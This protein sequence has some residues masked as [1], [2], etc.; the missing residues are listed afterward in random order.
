M[1]ETPSHIDPI[2][3][4]HETSDAHFKSVLVTGI[5]LLG[6]MVFGFVFSW[7]VYAFFNKQTASPGSHAE[8]L[9]RPDLSKRPAGPVLQADPHAELIALRRGEDSVLSTYGWVNRDSGVVRIPIDQAM[10]M[11][12]KKG[13]PHRET[14]GVN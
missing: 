2:A 9:T 13:L 6:L 12:V 4:K 5:V 1:S 8:T 7:G 14:K 10:E 11:L 3:R